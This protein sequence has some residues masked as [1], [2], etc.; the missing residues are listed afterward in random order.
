[1][2]PIQSV[3]GRAGGVSA[4]LVAMF[5]SVSAFAEG[6]LHSGPEG[7]RRRGRIVT[8]LDGHGWSLD[9]V[10]VSVPHTWNAVDGADGKGPRWS[11]SVSA[12]SYAHRRGVYVRELPGRVV[13]GRR[14]FVRC[15]G[16]SQKAVVRVNGVELGRHVGA[17]TAFAFEATRALKPTGNR[18]EIEVDNIVDRDVPPLAADFTVYGGLYRGVE[19]IETDPVCIDCVTDGARGVRLVPDAATGDVVAEV[20]VDGGTNEVRRFSF[21]NPERWSPESPRLY[22]VEIAVAQNGSYDAVRETFGFRTA[23]FRDDGFYLNGVKRQIRGVNYHQDMDGAG[24]AVSEEQHARDVALIREMGADG[25]RTAHYPHAGATYAACDRAGLLVWCEI[26]NV[27]DLGTTGVYRANA[28]ALA[29]ETVAQL[30]N[31]PSIVVWSVA[32]EYRTNSLVRHAGLKALVGDLVREVKRRDPTRAVAAAT[33]RSY[34]TDINLIPDVLGFNF[35][36]GWYRREAHEMRETVD[37]ALAETPRRTIGVTEYGAGGNVDCH[38]PP[39][40]RNAPLSPFHAEEYQ[41]WVHHA[42]YLSLVADDRVWGTYVWLMFDFGADARREGSRF[43]INDKGLVAFDHETKKDAFW[44]YKTNWNPEP[45]LH[46]VGT[47]LET[48]TNRFV[49]VMG[50]SN[51]GEVALVVNGREVG[52]Q[53]PDA[54]KTVIWRGVEMR[55]GRNRVE[56][57]A[58]GRTASARW[59]LQERLRPHLES[60]REM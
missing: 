36:P 30:G 16:A 53:A 21:P 39:D 11:N 29:R 58:G 52:R 55:P 7:G 13:A 41:A 45:T 3:C 31:H 15:L 32:N 59:T 51:V 28:L 60:A 50:F 54:V 9:G 5:F 26:P 6:V 34:L 2:N 56:L 43:G 40:A 23:E 35:Y 1:M 24:W 57:R 37:A 8:R 46:L 22:E 17:F 42:N 48:L 10:P 14:Y 38:A 27:N 20:R 49:T 19:W 47:R 12:P 18:L 33:C 44:F 4:L 25:L